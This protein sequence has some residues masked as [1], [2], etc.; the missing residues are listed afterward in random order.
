MGK[1]FK[2]QFFSKSAPKPIYFSLNIYFMRQLESLGIGG[3]GG[4]RPL[5][6]RPNSR[7]VALWFERVQKRHSGK[8]ATHSLARSLRSAHPLTHS[9]R[10][11][12]LHSARS[13]LSLRLLAHSLA[14]SA[15]S[16]AHS[17]ERRHCT[18]KSPASQTDLADVNA[19]IL[20]DSSHS[21]EFQTTR[22]T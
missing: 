19:S 2:I 9:L 14:R 7:G 4:H 12:P 18:H 21:G 1:L 13:A 3:G 22:P 11:D 6:W 15:H 5:A 10:H 8:W 16:L 17:W 20:T